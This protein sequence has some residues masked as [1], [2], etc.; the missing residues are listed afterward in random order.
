M[1]TKS[2]EVI[3]DQIIARLESGTIPWRKSWQASENCP[4][5]LV[6]KHEYRGI[7]VLILASAGYR[8]PYWL[9]YKQAEELGGFVKKGE[10]S[11]AICFWKVGT[12]TKVDDDGEEIEKKSFLLR[13]YRVFNLEQCEAP[14]AVLDRLPKSTGLDFDPIERCEA[15]VAGMPKRPEI[16][17]QAQNR[18]F[19]TPALDRVTMPEQKQFTSEAGYYEV[20]FH[21]LGHSTGHPSR[22]NRKENLN[23]W[24]AFGSKDYSKEELVAEMTAAFL[25]GESGIE[26]QT[27][28]NSAAYIQSW[29]KVLKNDKRMVILAASQA[30]KAADFILAKGVQNES[31]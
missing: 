25:C 15:I 30:Q 20:L 13:Y 24:A 14:Q 18:A 6:S 1:A 28:D 9:T 4:R 5:N 16:L 7:N 11:T 3:T 2:Y 27:I 21:E 29:L 8:S 17:H 12:Y 26:R 22:L 19:Y 31:C 10:K 23:K